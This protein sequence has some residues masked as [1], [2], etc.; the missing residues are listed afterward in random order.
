[1]ST[2]KKFRGVLEPDNTPLKW[3]IVK[4]PFDP[5]KAWPTRNRLRVKGTI[6]G[7]AF[8]T[9]LFGSAQGGHLLLVNKQMQ[10][11]AGASVGSMAEIVLEPDL[12]R[13]RHPRPA[14]AGKAAQAAWPVKKDGMSS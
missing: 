11:G 7:F 1:M 10:K 2:T 8:R 14:R 13:T 3:V 5:A 9:S 12:E 6:N 4:L